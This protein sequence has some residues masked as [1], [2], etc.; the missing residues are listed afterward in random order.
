MMRRLWVVVRANVETNPGIDHSSNT[1]GLLTRAAVS[2]VIE[3]L[4][5]FAAGDRIRN[6]SAS[7]QQYTLGAA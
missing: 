1:S 3:K 6:A 4:K 2:G 7:R 5:V